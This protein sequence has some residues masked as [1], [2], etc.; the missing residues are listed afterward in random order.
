MKLPAM[1]SELRIIG[2][3][4]RNGVR[5][6]VHPELINGCVIRDREAV[7]VEALASEGSSP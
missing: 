4:R 6:G 7:L 3:A 5:L 1:I 2:R